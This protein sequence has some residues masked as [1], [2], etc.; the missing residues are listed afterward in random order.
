MLKAADPTQ[1]L[2]LL[3]GGSMLLLYGVK[4]ITDAMGRAFGT[5]LQLAMMTLADRPLTSFGVGIVVTMLTQSS[6]ATASIMIGLVSSQLIPL[7]A[8][9][10]MLLGASVGS[11][12]IVQLLAFKFTDYA[13]E[14]LGLATTFAFLSRRSKL[15]D[16]GRAVF[17]FSLVIVG[18]AM[19]G[20]SSTPIA[21][22][23][24]T[25]AIMQTLAQS[26]LVLLLLGVLLA[27]VFVSSIAAIGIVIVL[28]SGG[29]LP[30]TAA[31]AVMLGANI[32]TTITPLLTA[33]NQRNIAGRRLGLIYMGTR[34]A[35]VIV[36]M[37]L[38][39]PLANLLTQFLPNPATQVAIAHMAFNVILAIAFVPLANRL[40]NLATLFFPAPDKNKK[41]K[42]TLYYLDLEALNLPA[43]ALSQA[44]REVL[45]MSDL[46]TEMLQLSIQ[47]FEAGTK[48]LPKRVSNLDDQLDDLESAIKNYLIQLNDETLTEEQVQRELCLLHISTELEAIGDIIDRQLMRLARRKRR[49][50]IAFPQPQWDDIVSYYREVLG[51]LQRVLAG[52]AT[53]DI[54]IAEEVLA[55][56]QYLN[57]IKREMH[58]R[59]LQQLSSGT[60]T[61]LDASS[62]YLETVNAMS[63]ISSHTC[64]I[65]RAVQG[66]L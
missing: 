26:P 65:A 53:Q 17:S 59:H 24:I 66:D 9:V 10:V 5:K 34:L 14:F 13:L 46:A 47:A 50:Q 57:Q 12:L 35:G 54:E 23:A 6:T 7:A 37:L 22:S 3:L 38:I 28:A 40:A 21:D 15:R 63:R 41:S 55:H 42:K 4:L 25:R 58:S 43:V 30:L 61:D 49:K 31:L 52:V 1:L 36:A 39:N 27:A 2:I 8:A 45:R 32:G 33:L 16:I 60:P 20:A 51:L 56:R 29:A 18:L 62:I 19:I 64:S 44:M 48:D 11:T